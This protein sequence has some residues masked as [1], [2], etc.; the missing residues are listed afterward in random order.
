MTIAQIIIDNQLG[1][2]IR[3]LINIGKPE[4][5]ERVWDI[6]RNLYKEWD[7]G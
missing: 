7:N 4:L 2:L 6:R 1:A 5:V 3:D